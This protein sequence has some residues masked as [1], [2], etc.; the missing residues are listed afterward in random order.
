MQNDQQAIRGLIDEWHKAAAV[1]DLSKILELMAPDVA[2]YVVGQPPMRGRETFAAAF[3]SVV[4]KVR[5]ASTAKIEE[6]RIA[7]NFAYLVSYLTLAMT[8]LQGGPVM[9]RSGYTLTIMRK[10]P[11]GRWLLYRDANML[12]PE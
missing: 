7:G 6:L 1:G 4:Q 2:F 12:T 9:R 10:E 3:R 5:I 11:D 8:P